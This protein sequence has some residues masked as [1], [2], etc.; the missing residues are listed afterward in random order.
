M[1]LVDDIINGKQGH[2]KVAIDSIDPCGL[3]PLHLAAKWGRLPVVKKLLESGANLKI[4]DRKGRTAQ[5][6]AA[7]SVLDA[8]E[9]R[10]SDRVRMALEDDRRAIFRHAQLLRSQREEGAITDWELEDAT[11]R[12][13]EDRWWTHQLLEAEV[14][15]KVRSEELDLQKREEVA[16]YLIHRPQEMKEEAYA[17]IQTALRKREKEA[18]KAALMKARLDEIRENEERKVAEAQREAKREIKELRRERTCGRCGQLYTNERNKGGQCV[19]K[20]TWANWATDKH[21]QKVEWLFYWTCCKSQE[22][23]GPAGGHS[24]CSRSEAHEESEADMARRQAKML[25]H[26]SIAANKHNRARRKKT[27]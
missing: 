17:N 9:D 10:E 18:K 6:V 22:F 7:Q 26:A 11:K 4:K 1:E 16:E 15:D 25:K 12:K 23:E 8:F 27:G 24:Q 13:E 14:E 21:G 20:G 3:T 2:L 5:D 19:H